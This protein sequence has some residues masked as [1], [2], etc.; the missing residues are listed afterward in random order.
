M[1]RAARIDANQNEVAT[2]A[3]TQKAVCLYVKA[4]YPKAIF[5]SDLSGIKLSIGLATKLKNLKS[6]RGIPDWFCPIASRGY[7][8]L[9]LELKKPGIKLKKRD[10]NWKSEHL[11]EQSDMID[12]LKEEGY[13]ASFA[14]GFDQAKELID[15]YLGGKR[16]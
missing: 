7:T 1:R 3:Q 15:W 16:V 14:I 8:G 11:K 6:H 12:S 9:F 10:G 13:F 2:E 4:Q 5:W